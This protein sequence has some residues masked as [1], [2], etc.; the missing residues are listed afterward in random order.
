[1]PLVLSQQVTFYRHNFLKFILG[2]A[3]ITELR[4]SELQASA[5][6]SRLGSLTGIFTY[7]KLPGTHGQGGP[8][9]T[10]ACQP[11][12]TACGLSVSAHR[13]CGQVIAKPRSARLAGTGSRP[14]Q[15]KGD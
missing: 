6:R 2:K 5:P 10:T 12:G 4:S 7:G 11:G 3:L 15:G 9:H 1:M 14:H 8:R 13:G